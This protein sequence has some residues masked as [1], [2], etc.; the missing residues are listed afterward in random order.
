[1]LFFFFFFLLVLLILLLL[2][3]RLLPLW[4]VKAVHVA[5]CG[6]MRN[7]H[8]S[9][10]A[11][12]QRWQC[13]R[14]FCVGVNAPRPCPHLTRSTGSAVLLRPSAHPPNRPTCGKCFSLMMPR[15]ISNL[16]AGFTNCTRTAFSSTSYSPSTLLSSRWLPVDHIETLCTYLSFISFVVSFWATWSHKIEIN[17]NAN[18][19]QQ[20]DFPLSGNAPICRG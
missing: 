20:V 8:Q 5:D 9:R 13:L 7:H 2:L 11:A 18:S 1:M 17:I 6:C 14:D 3:L 12:R 10:L 15:K 4:A 19:E 16:Y